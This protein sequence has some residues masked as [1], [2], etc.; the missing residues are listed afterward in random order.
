MSKYVTFIALNFIVQCSKSI[1]ISIEG[2]TWLS[3]IVSFKL[4][5]KVLIA[6]YAPFIYFLCIG[7]T[8]Y[9]L[10]PIIIKR[11]TQAKNFFWVL[12]YRRPYSWCRSSEIFILSPL[13]SWWLL[14]C[15]I[16]LFILVHFW[17]FCVL[18]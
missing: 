6:I 13:Y 10:M 1:V 17:I 14:P 2:L 12:V 3:E 15:M 5:P 4:I 9:N 7:S 18:L 16:I 8:I 11:V